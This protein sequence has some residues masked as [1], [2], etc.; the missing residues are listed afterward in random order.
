MVQ[1]SPVSRYDHCSPD[2]SLPLPL[3]TS[4]LTTSASSIVH[5][6]SNKAGWPVVVEA[7]TAAAVE[8]T[9]ATGVVLR[10]VA[11]GLRTV[12]RPLCGHYTQQQSFTND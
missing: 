11:F 9:V 7:F 10:L 4:L 2:L 1:K 5:A 3:T 8:G 6:S 12:G